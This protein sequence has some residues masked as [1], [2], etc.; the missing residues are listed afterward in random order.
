M[1]DHG[2]DT[3][4]SEINEV[5]LLTAEQEI[6]LAERVQTGDMGAREHMIRANLRLVVSIAKNYVNRGLTFMDLIE[7]GNIGLMKAV[8]KFDPEAGCRFSTYATWWIKQGIR[9]ALVNT[10]KTVRVPSYM[11]EIVSKW[12]ATAMELNYQLGRQATTGEIAEELGL[13]ESNWDVVRDTVLANSQP[14]FSMNEDASSVVGEQLVDGRSRQPDEVLFE[15]LEIRR[16]L[17]LMDVLDE[18]ERRIL[19]MRYGLDDGEPMTLKA[20]GHEVGLTRE[21][22]RQMEVEALHKLHATLSREFDEDASGPQA[23][24]RRRA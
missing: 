9:R 16:L 1:R 15:S 8:E 2:L 10:V 22:V 20:I 14:T 13:P 5:A 21:R 7:E 17:E 24:L 12:K 4:L 3:Y 19:R 23:R 18:R 11:S 6:Q